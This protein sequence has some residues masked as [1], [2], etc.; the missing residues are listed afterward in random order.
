MPAR[1]EPAVPY[2]KLDVVT[3]AP[4]TVSDKQHCNTP[5]CKQ[6]RHQL[7][8]MLVYI[9]MYIFVDMYCPL[10][11]HKH[12]GLYSRINLSNKSQAQAQKPSSDL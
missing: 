2:S 11:R 6:L 10:S 4:T 8:E 5:L 7:S 12:L 9:V 3:T 1:I